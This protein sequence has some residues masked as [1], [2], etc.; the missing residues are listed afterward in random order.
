MQILLRMRIVRPRF[1]LSYRLLSQIRNRTQSELIIDFLAYLA[2]GARDQ[3][4][5]STEDRSYQRRNAGWKQKE[6]PDTRQRH[7]QSTGILDTTR[8]IG[9]QTQSDYQ[10][11][12]MLRIVF[13]REVY[14]LRF[15]TIEWTA[16]MV[17]FTMISLSSNHFANFRDYV[18]FHSASD[19]ST[20]WLF[21]YLSISLTTLN[22]QLYEILDCLVRLFDHSRNFGF[23]R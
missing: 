18:K 9:S 19:Y 5:R 15:W 17:S 13:I 20:I 22:S 8:R 2:K 16:A 7:N 6:F 4:T 21:A 14:R 1:R 10:W 11:R 12:G 3:S 23:F